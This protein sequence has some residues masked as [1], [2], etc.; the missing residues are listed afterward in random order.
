[1]GLIKNYN[2]LAT[3]PERKLVLDVVNAGLE[4]IQPDH[5]INK[6]FSVAD[7]QLKVIHKS[8]DLSQY[9]RVSLIGF[10]K[11]SAGI[12][13]L[14]EKKLGDRLTEGYCIDVRE[15]QFQQIHFTLGT[16]PLP[17]QANIDYTKTV[18]GKFSSLTE[19]DLV[20]VVICGGGSVMFAHPEHI[21][22]DQL[23]E[24]NKALLHAGMDILKMNTI[25]KHLDSVKGGGLAK[26]LHPAAVVSLIFSDVP[27]NDLSFIAS[28]PTVKDETTTD[29]AFR[30]LDEYKI[31]EQIQLKDEDYIE[32]PKDDAVFENVHNCIM[33]SNV[34]A[35]DAMKDE[36]LHQGVHV[37]NHSDRVQGNA[38]EVAKQLLDSTK[39]E[40]LLLAAGETTIKITGEGKGGRNQ[41]LVLS[42]LTTIEE[43]AVIASVAS[44]GQ[45]NSDH[46][47]A[48]GDAQIREKAAKENLSIDEYLKNND[49]YHFFEKTGD[50]ILTEK[51]ASNVADLFVVY[52]K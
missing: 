29:D 7:N 36:A 8:F 52:K 15:E 3:T 28:G 42:T 47:G 13:K 9:E 35:L 25:R 39:P 34:T 45:D 18:I 21:T 22:L 43:G 11:G 31:R 30:L 32:T 1:M 40:H 41:E 23:T 51:L 12:S 4:A 6:N 48:I 37:L 33:V 46:A 26:I 14:I 10:G 38:H 27:G 50:A 19:K 17:S 24:V 2:E 16:H 44:D 49:S 20:I 5:I